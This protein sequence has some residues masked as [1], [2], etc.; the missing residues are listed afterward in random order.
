[1]LAVFDTDAVC[2]IVERERI[3]VFPGA[4]TLYQ[5]LLGA[6][7]ARA[8]HDIS[9]LRLAVTGAADIPVELIRRVKEELPFERILTGYGLTEAG[10]G[11]GCKPDDDFEHI[12]STVGIPW[13][14]F[15]VQIAA[16]QGGE[17]ATGEP[18]E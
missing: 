4:P 14:G 2:E 6:T 7:A 10:T 11:T 3:T 8:R 12:A 15:E 18:G 5:S 16:E 17:V 13:P 9:S 1:P